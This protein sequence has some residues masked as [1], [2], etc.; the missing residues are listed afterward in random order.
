MSGPVVQNPTVL[1]FL[2]GLKLQKNFCGQLGYILRYGVINFHPELISFSFFLGYAIFQ[3]ASFP[4]FYLKICLSSGYS[5]DICNNLSGETQD[6]VQSDTT[7]WQT[8]IALANFATSTFSAVFFGSFGDKYGWR[9]PALMATVSTAVYFSLQSVFLYFS[10][11]VPWTFVALS[12]F[13]GIG[14]GMTLIILAQ[15]SYVANLTQEW[16]G[17]EAINDRLT[18]RYAVLTAFWSLAYVVG[19]YISGALLSV[20]DFHQCMT[21]GIGVIAFAFLLILCTYRDKI[22]MNSSI[23]SEVKLSTDEKLSFCSEASRDFKQLYV[24]A[25]KTLTKKRVGRKRLYLAAVISLYVFYG[26]EDDGLSTV[27]GLYVFADPFSWD[28]TLLAY[29]FGTQS[30]CNMIGSLIS[31]W[32][33]KKLKFRDSTVAIIGMFSACLRMALDAVGT[34]T[35]VMFIGCF[36][37]FASTV[38]YSGMRAFVVQLGD[39]NETGQLVS[40]ITVTS[41]LA[42]VFAALAYNSIYRATLEIWKGAVFAF[43][44]ALMLVCMAVMTAIHFDDIKGEKRRIKTATLKF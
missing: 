38:G 35:A 30:F 14:G 39:N 26:S 44:A 7:L 24:D 40:T 22:N 27:I 3:A 15:Y 20:L 37:G 21:V 9:I 43:T 13:V 12:G 34:N 16:G 1:P 6:S 42:P 31:A 17:T 41:G 4:A 36:A 29:Y 11:F 28:P 23:Q 19:E 2:A 5:N 32:V 10:I 8:Y 33:M 25:Y 18:L